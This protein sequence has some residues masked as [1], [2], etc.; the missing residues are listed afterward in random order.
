MEMEQEPFD[1]DDL[2]YRINMI[3][4][5]PYRRLQDGTLKRAGL[6]LL[7]EFLRDSNPFIET[8]LKTPDRKRDLL[9]RLYFVT[10]LFT[11]GDLM[12]GCVSFKSH[13]EGFAALCQ[14]RAIVEKIRGSFYSQKA[15]IT[16]IMEET[17]TSYNGRDFSQEPILADWLALLSRFG[18]KARQLLREGQQINETMTLDEIRRFRDALVQH[19]AEN[20][21]FME[22]LFRDERFLSAFSSHMRLAWP[23]VLIN[24]LYMM[25]PAL[26]LTSVD[27]IALCYYA[28]RAVE[29]AFQCDLTNILRSNIRAVLA[30]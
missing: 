16:T 4:E 29:T 30:S 1:A 11:S 3:S 8:I 21:E 9:L 22:L 5:R 17:A 2:D 27:R 19:E 20:S 14:N 24:L 23:R 12:S 18:K 25:V 26:G 6:E 15:L 7:H 10:A 13:W 28:H